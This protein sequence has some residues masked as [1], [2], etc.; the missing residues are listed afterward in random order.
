MIS[1]LGS[2]HVD[3]LHQLTGDI[4]INLGRYTSYHRVYT[5]YHCVFMACKGSCCSVMLASFANFIYVSWVDKQSLC[6]KCKS[7][8]SIN[9]VFCVSSFFFNYCI[10]KLKLPLCSVIFNDF[11]LLS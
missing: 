9:F 7:V 3:Y 6:V 4:C 1:S 8:G 5:S 11:H 10:F 2:S